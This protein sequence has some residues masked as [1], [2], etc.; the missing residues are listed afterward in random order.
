M[1]SYVLNQQ[2]QSLQDVHQTL[3]TI[4]QSNIAVIAA[5]N[6][7]SRIIPQTPNTIEGP[8]SFVVSIKN[9]LYE[10]L[11]GFN[12][13]ASF[14]RVNGGSDLM[15]Y[16][17]QWIGLV[18]V[19]RKVTTTKAWRANKQAYEIENDTQK[20]QVL[21]RPVPWL[22]RTGA[23]ISFSAIRAL[24][25]SLK[26]QS[27]IEPIRYTIIP[28]AAKDAMYDGDLDSLKRMLVKGEISMYDRCQLTGANLVELCLDHLLPTF[29]PEE[30]E[31]LETPKSA[32]V[33]VLLW[34]VSQGLNAEFQENRLLC[35]SGKD[36]DE[37]LF[38][39]TQGLTKSKLG[40]AAIAENRERLA[41]AI[42]EEMPPVL[43]AQR[44]LLFALANPSHSM[45]LK[46][47]IWDL[48]ED[49]SEEG[50]TVVNQKEHAFWEQSFP[51]FGMESVI[52][53]S[54]MKMRKASQVTEEPLKR[55]MEEDARKGPRR[56]LSKLLAEGTRL[57]DDC[58]PLVNNIANFL[59]LSKEISILENSFSHHLT[60]FACRLNLLDIWHDI[61]AKASLPATDL[62]SQHLET[63]DHLTKPLWIS[64]SKGSISLIAR[65]PHTLQ[66]LEIDDFYNAIEPFQQ[67]PIYDSHAIEGHSD[68]CFVRQEGTELFF[69]CGVTD[70]EFDCQG[71]W[72]KE[73]EFWR[74]F[75]AAHDRYTHIELEPAVEQSKVGEEAGKIGGVGDNSL[76][77]SPGLLSR[78]VAGGISVISGIV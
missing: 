26:I 47:L 21:I 67:Q 61:L 25:G 64:S 10:T 23:D 46:S 62:L 30:W 37:W 60:T 43:R 27:T 33:C 78:V 9:P 76:A 52:I 59:V 69:D 12:S 19:T 48:L 38:V 28:Q 5:T 58:Q 3:T 6:H 18:K 75:D 8:T 36:Q 45:S 49:P 35:R 14:T 53:S 11:N 31:E 29:W 57:R 56:I 16:H 74:E 39:Q 66:A 4:Q 70:P 50:L 68:I 71:H 17:N 55:I 42:T 24:Y 7:L 63:D 34:L 77:T 22:F 13:A 73:V 1:Y 32:I 44:L 20:T 51:L 65:D 2:S 41:I 72:D 15:V 40:A 54:L